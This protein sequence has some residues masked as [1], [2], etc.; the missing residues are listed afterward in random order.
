MA[1]PKKAAKKSA[2][3]LVDL[4]VEEVKALPK[5]REGFEA[6]VEGLLAAHAKHKSELSSAKVD[7]GKVR[8]NIEAA[9]KLEA[10]IADAK[11]QLELLEETRLLLRSHAWSDVLAIYGV[12]QVVAK[13]DAKVAKSI[14]PFVRFM[15]TGAKKKKA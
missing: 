15:S 1:T 11:K 6:H 8:A 13:S 3:A 9:A 10:A 4:T 2:L 5:P 12:A 14:E 7:A